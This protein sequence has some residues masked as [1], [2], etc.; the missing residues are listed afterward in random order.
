MSKEHAVTVVIPAHNAESTLADTLQSLLAQTFTGFEAIVVDDGSTDSTAATASS[1]GDPRVRV[2]SIQRGGVSRARNLGIAQAMG[3]YIAFLDAD[4]LWEPQK[5]ALQVER[6][7][8]RPDVGICVTRAISIDA[9]SKVIGPRPLLTDTD[10]YTEALLLGSMIAGCISSAVVRREVIELVGQFVL[11]QT[12]C[13]DWDLWLRLSLVTNFAVIPEPL[14]RYRIHDGNSS[15]D[16]LALERDTFA[17]LDRFFSSPQSAD[18]R[19]L[20]R[21]AYAHHWMVCSGA[22]FQSGALVQAFRCGARGAIAQPSSTT[23]AL[24]LPARRLRRALGTASSHK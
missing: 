24:G 15:G 19:H 18:H 22:Y 10:D 13:E 9:E 3:R 20:R 7:D 8:E 4:D 17:T 1:T 12:H 23:K 2:L 11:D 16:A 14:V 6:L 21:R 5:L